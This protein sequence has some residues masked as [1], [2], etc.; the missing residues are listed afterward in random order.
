[1]SAFGRHAV[2]IFGQYHVFITEKSSSWFGWIIATAPMQTLV[3]NVSIRTLPMFVLSLRDMP[4]LW[5]N[6]V[7]IHW[8]KLDSLCLAVCV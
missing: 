4:L 8:Q 3:S 7:N 2:H 5:Y 6:I 1:M